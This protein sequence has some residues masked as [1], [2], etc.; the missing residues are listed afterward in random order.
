MAEGVTWISVK[1]FAEAT[2]ISVQMVY[3]LAQAGVIDSPTKGQLP[4]PAS[5]INYCKHLRGKRSYGDTL[6]DERTKLTKIQAEI[7]DLELRQLKGEL[8]SHEEVISEFTGRVVELR[9]ALVGYPKKLAPVL[10]GQDE[11]TIHRILDEEFT[12]LLMRFSREGR[13]TTRGK[14]DGKKSDKKTKMVKPRKGGGK[15]SR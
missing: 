11:I 12:D 13:W 3:K 9:S 5:N 2:G 15:A 6:T 14:A 10:Y 8:I 4:W 1:R 7:K